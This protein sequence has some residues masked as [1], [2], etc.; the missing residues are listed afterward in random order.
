MVNSEIKYVLLKE[1]IVHA[2]YGKNS[3]D[4]K[5]YASMARISGNDELPSE[6]FGDSL[7]LTSCILDSRAT[8]HMT[9]EV[10]DCIPGLLEDTDKHIEVVGGHHVTKKRVITYNNVRQ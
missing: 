10:S 2:K 3:S 5:I 9:P 4:Q 8:C 1:V 6:N 7:Q